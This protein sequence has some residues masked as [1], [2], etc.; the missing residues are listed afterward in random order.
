MDLSCGNEMVV[1]VLYRQDTN[2][3]QDPYC[4]KRLTTMMVIC[5]DRKKVVRGIMAGGR[6]G[7]RKPTSGLDV[8]KER[9]TARSDRRGNGTAPQA[10]QI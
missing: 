8:E 9:D 6:A 10:N 4:H 2:A 3:H 7:R 5:E 1:D